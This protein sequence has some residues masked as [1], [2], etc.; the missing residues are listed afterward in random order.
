M[1]DHISISLRTCVQETPHAADQ[2]SDRLW[3]HLGIG[4]VDD[5]VTVLGF[6]DG[7]IEHTDWAPQGWWTTQNIYQGDVYVCGLDTFEHRR[8][9]NTGSNNI[10][11]TCMQCGIHTSRC[12]F[13]M[14]LCASI[15]CLLCVIL[16]CHGY[17]SWV[18]ERTVCLLLRKACACMFNTRI[19]VFVFKCHIHL[20]TF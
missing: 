1:S 17:D 8:G 20:H 7:L 13:I 15:V 11:S 16:A 18:D 6:P 3:Q 19:S 14:C 2:D 5:A 4:L 12:A 10:V 9:K